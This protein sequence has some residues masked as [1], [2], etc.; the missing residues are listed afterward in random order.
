MSRY[1]IDAR[2]TPIRIRARWLRSPASS[3]NHGQPHERDDPAPE[4][5]R[6][7]RSG[8]VANDHLVPTGWHRDGSEAGGHADQRRG[9]AIDG[10]DEIGVPR[11]LHER[12]ARSFQLE[13]RPVRLSLLRF[14]GHVRPLGVSIEAGRFRQRLPAAERRCEGCV[15]VE[16]VDDSLAQRA[17]R[18]PSRARVVAGRRG[19]VVAAGDVH[20]AEVAF[21]RG[22]VDGEAAGGSSQAEMRRHRLVGRRDHRAY[23]QGDVVRSIGL[24][25]KHHD[26]RRERHRVIQKADVI[27]MIAGQKRVEGDRSDFEITPPGGRLPRRDASGALGENRAHVPD[28]RV[29]V[30]AL[31]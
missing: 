8:R 18:E 5:N 24:V 29:D 11:D 26:V 20:E 9:L 27:E 30:S 6:L 1:E 23:S 19:G 25:A 12:V 7:Q 22:L 14:G 31:A 28:R 15:R 21:T 13:L 10:R 2:S 17:I 4:Q 16:R 3:R